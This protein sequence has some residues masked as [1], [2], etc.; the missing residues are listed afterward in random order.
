MVIYLAITMEPYE[1]GGYV[2]K[3]SMVV[4]LSRHEWAAHVAHENK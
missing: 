2:Q 3:K 1:Y 4:A